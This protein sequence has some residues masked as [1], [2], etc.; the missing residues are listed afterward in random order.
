[1]SALN[2]HYSMHQWRLRE[3][4]PAR[5][6]FDSVRLSDSEGVLCSERR[7]EADWHGP[8]YW[9]SPGLILGTETLKHLRLSWQFIVKGSPPSSLSYTTGRTQPNTR[10]HWTI[11]QMALPFES[12][13]GTYSNPLKA[14]A[15]T[16]SAAVL[17]RTKAISI[18]G[19][20][21]TA[22]WVKAHSRLNG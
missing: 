18:W 17:I 2:E 11:A 10:R 7:R 19:N 6:E 22:A 16:Q 5:A 3:G 15:T 8:A 12:A 20:V 21:S 14:T 1:M 9:R 13:L 4:H